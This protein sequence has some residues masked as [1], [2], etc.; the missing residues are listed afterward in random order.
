MSSANP[1]PDQLR[2]NDQGRV[3]DKRQ[4]LLRCDPPVLIIA[5]TWHETRAKFA[6][7][8]RDRLLLSYVNNEEDVRAPLVYHRS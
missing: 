3:P 5:L 4:I 8:F 6:T 2:I 1:T 7:Y